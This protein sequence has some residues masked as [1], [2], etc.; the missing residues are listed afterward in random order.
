MEADNSFT[1]HWK[2]DNFN[3]LRG[4]RKG[5]SDK[6]NITLAPVLTTKGGKN[7]NMY[8]LLSKMFLVYRNLRH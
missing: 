4:H 7:L 1:Y 5:P 3:Q 8:S 6:L 2:S